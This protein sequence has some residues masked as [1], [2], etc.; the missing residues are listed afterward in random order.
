MNSTNDCDM[1]FSIDHSNNGLIWSP[2]NHQKSAQID[3]SDQIFL[4]KKANDFPCVGS[5]NTIDPVKSTLTLHF[6][7]SPNTCTAMVSND[8]DIINS[9]LD[10]YKKFGMVFDS[11]IFHYL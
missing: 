8:D 11:N 10:I 5:Q 2:K 7:H 1:N 9:P 3:G 6:D 4:E